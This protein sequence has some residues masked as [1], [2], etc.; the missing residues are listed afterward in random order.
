MTL[1]RP[2]TPPY[3]RFRIRRFVNCLEVCVVGLARFPQLAP[4]MTIFLRKYGDLPQKSALH[5]DR[6]LDRFGF[7]GQGQAK[8]LQ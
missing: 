6:C 4:L 1:P 2:L 5:F 3:V 8:F 7:V